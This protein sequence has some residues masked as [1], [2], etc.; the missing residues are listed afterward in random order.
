MEVNSV[1]LSMHGEEEEESPSESVAETRKLG[2]EPS[3]SV[4]TKKDMWY[5][6]E[7]MAK[8][9]GRPS[10]WGQDDDEFLARDEQQ[11][12]KPRGRKARTSKGKNDTAGDEAEPVRKRGRPAKRPAEA[13]EAT[14]SKR[15]TRAKAKAKSTPKAKAKATAKAKAKG[16]AK[17]GSKANSGYCAP[18]LKEPDY[19]ARQS[20]KSGAYHRTLKESRDK[21]FD[22]EKCRELARKVPR[23]TT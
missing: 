5:A 1:S 3:G 8:M 6:Q 23:Q 17:A 20:R 12:P 9:F 19:K 11:P 13:S 15:K 7:Q 14:G 4:T 21:G 22:E 2:E 16:K 18:C 10:F